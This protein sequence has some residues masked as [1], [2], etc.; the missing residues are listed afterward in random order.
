MVDTQYSKS[1][2][3]TNGKILLTGASGTIGKEIA[4]LFSFK[5][6]SIRAGIHSLNKLNNIN[7]QKIEII[8]LDYFNIPTIVNSVKN[9]QTIILIT[10]N[11]P[12]QVEIATTI[13]DYAKDAGVEY[14]IKLSSTGAAKEIG[15][16]VGRLHRIVERYI[17]CSGLD[18]T[19]IRS[20]AL[21]QN[22]INMY[23]ITN[24]KI[25]LPWSN[26]KVS[27]IN[28]KDIANFIFNILNT[29]SSISRNEHSKKIYTITSS[30][31]LNL[32]EIAEIF[33]SIIGKRIIYE[34]I[35]LENAKNQLKS[36][37][38]SDWE[39]NAIMELFEYFKKGS[40]AILTNT[41]EEV[42]KQKPTTFA[43]FVKTNIEKFKLFTR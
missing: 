36:L 25:A 22:F 9:I 37:V 30:E 5:N 26:S 20:T 27:F 18:Y 41:Y 40:N 17:F 23:S 6:I 43:E 4:K 2:A 33:S 3:N 38:K 21:M 28:S 34:D 13:I 24:N 42:T 11:I 32:Y 35:S 19:I 1:M 15:T 39:I 12:E 16:L 29:K 10:P 14:I 7:E 31:S 8:E